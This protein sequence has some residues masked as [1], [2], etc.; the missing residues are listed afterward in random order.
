MHKLAASTTIIIN[1]TLKLDI[2][3]YCGSSES[4][5]NPLPGRR[6]GVNFLIACDTLHLQKGN[7]SNPSQVRSLTAPR[8]VLD[9]KNSVQIK[10]PVQLGKGYCNDEA[11]YLTICSWL[12]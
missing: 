11:Q 10:Y 3:F 7:R 2:T 4:L 5:H 9:K 1:Y 6:E 8:A 12:T